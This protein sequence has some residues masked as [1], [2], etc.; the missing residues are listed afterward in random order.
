MG[1]THA[2]ASQWSDSTNVTKTVDASATSIPRIAEQPA[3]L[4]SVFDQSDE[5]GVVD[6]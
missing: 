1:I 5:A 6:D 2:A 4:I 3:V